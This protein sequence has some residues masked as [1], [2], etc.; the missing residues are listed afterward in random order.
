MYV[1][2]VDFRVDP[3]HAADFSHA[4][5]INARSSTAKEPGCRQFDVTVDE[6]DPGHFF[7]YEVY[8]H[9]PAFQAH[10]ETDHF[11][12]VSTAIAPWVTEKTV[13]TFFR[14]D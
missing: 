8:D 10:M 13:R 5:R 3:E 7:L 4:M 9:E 1:V 11:L 6:F 12:A 14:I 2:T